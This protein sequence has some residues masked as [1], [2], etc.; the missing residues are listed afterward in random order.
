MRLRGLEC[1]TEPNGLTLAGLPS[2]MDMSTQLARLQQ[3]LLWQLHTKH[4]QAHYQRKM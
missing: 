3:G 1:N 2:I 4:P